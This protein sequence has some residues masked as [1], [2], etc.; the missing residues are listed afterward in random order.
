MSQHRFLFILPFYPWPL[1]SGGH[2][3]VF[4]GIRSVVGF[5]D[6]HLV[7]YAGQRETNSRYDSILKEQLGGN[8]SIH[9][10]VDKV[11][12][13]AKDMAFRKISNKISK[14]MDYPSYF[15]HAIKLHDEAFYDYVNNLIE[16]YQ[17]DLVQVEM[18]QNLDFILTLPDTVKTVFVH[19]ELCF[20]RNQQYVARMGG[21]SYIK[22]L[23]E[24][25]KI[26]EIA[27]L[28]RYDMVMTL[29]E[30][31]K[32]KL[33]E[34]CV[35]APIFASFGIV[36]TKLAALSDSGAGSH[37]AVYVGPEAHYPNKLGLMWFMDNVWPLVKERDE[38]FSLDIVGRW[39]PAT[40]SE[41]S[42][43]YKDVHFLG[44]VDDLPSALKGGT[45]IVPIRVGSGIRMKI[46]EA[47]SL[48]VPFVSTVVG[49][50]GIPVKDGIHGFITDDPAVF[51]DRIIKAEDPDIRKQ[52][53]A[54]G[55]QLIREHYSEEALIENK[56]NAYRQLLGTIC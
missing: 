9:H 15:I 12:K 6:V 51:A 50:E 55:I 42:R 21:N 44:F 17:I 4:N 19:H 2:Q 35:T 11:G 28:N 45:M 10:Y 37:R 7:Y 1:V 47:M 23:Y 34:A 13:W 18:V 26:D 32:E 27:L 22:A 31:D 16:T 25:E 43:K 48:G 5:A 40:V 39:S 24:R 52:F 33:K 36:N 46:L 29:S 54:K 53:I 20:V 41:W 8:V 49:A 3:A 30:I 38:A 56:K 14:R